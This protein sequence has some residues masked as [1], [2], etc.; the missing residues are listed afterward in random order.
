MNA[1]TLR[2]VLTLAAATGML[3]S[4]AYVAGPA[5]GCRR[6]GLRAGSRD[7]EQHCRAGERQPVSVNR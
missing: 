4:S 1:D 7:R 5:F 3:A 2:R 6:T